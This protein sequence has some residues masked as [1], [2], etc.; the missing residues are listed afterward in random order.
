LPAQLEAGAQIKGYEVHIKLSLSTPYLG[1][2]I[3][4]PNRLPC[5]G[6]VLVVYFKFGGK[7]V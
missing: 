4:G 2:S 5:D 1:A 7:L 6:Q 3:S